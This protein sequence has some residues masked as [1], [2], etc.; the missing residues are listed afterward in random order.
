MNQNNSNESLS[1][2]VPALSDDEIV[3]IELAKGK[4]HDAIDQLHQYPSIKVDAFIA[5]ALANTVRTILVGARV[6]TE[7]NFHDVFAEKVLDKLEIVQDMVG[8]EAVD[9]EATDE[10]V[11]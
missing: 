7:Q 3:D 4:L 6:T 11:G 9:P 2:N 10:T 8:V 5:K 1:P